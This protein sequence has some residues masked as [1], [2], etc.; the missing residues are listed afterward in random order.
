LAEP[1]FE[2]EKS[3]SKFPS[4]H[5]EGGYV[6]QL[7]GTIGHRR[8]VGAVLRVWEF[9]QDLLLSHSVD[10]ILPQSNTFLCSRT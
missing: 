7:D 4:D 9:R 3:H 5:L 2:K 10:R 6:H 8:S 1:P